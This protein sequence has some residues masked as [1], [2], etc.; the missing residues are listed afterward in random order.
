MEH[1]PAYSV[2]NFATIGSFTALNV[3][4]PFTTTF[5]REDIT[6]V[7]NISYPTSQD[8]INAS[9]TL[10][11]STELIGV[12]S[13][14]NTTRY[15]KYLVSELYIPTVNSNYCGTYVCSARDMFVA[16]STMGLAMVEV[17][18]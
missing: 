9:A 7:C 15:D 16:Q 10:V 1:P 18:E 8:L 2:L 14:Q 17:G 3:E 4:T 13:V 6:L 5:L 11:W 12:I